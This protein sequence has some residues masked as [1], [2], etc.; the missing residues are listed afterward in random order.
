MSLKHRPFQLSNQ[1]F[2]C[3][4]FSTPKLKNE[5]SC[6][7]SPTSQFR[8]VCLIIFQ[9]FAS[10]EWIWVDEYYQAQTP[11]Y[12]RQGATSNSRQPP[13]GLHFQLSTQ[14]SLCANI[15]IA[16][17]MRSLV[18]AGSL[19]SGVI[20]LFEQHGHTQGSLSSLMNSLGLWIAKRYPERAVL[21]NP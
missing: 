15:S 21:K 2:V 19:A 9:L 5:T 18:S 20:N 1:R 6:W 4:L 13:G 8:V 17:W 14:R 7:S 11:D 3:T 16:H 10:G 12:T